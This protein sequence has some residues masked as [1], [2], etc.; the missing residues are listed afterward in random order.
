VTTSP[1]N[2]LRPTVS[3]ITA[4]TT[5]V[6]RTEQLAGEA[7]ARELDGVLVSASVSVRY[8]SGYTGSHGIVLL[9]SAPSQPWRFFTDFRYLT[10]AAEQVPERFERQIATN[11]FEAAL[12]SLQELGS[13]GGRLGFEDEHVSVAQH[14]KLLEELPSGWELVPCTGMVEGLRE[15]KDA[16]ELARIRAAAELVDEVLGWQA[17]RGLTGRSEREVALELEHE[18]RRRGA[19]AP[20]FPSIV[21]SGAQ[22]A[23]P[24]ASPRDVTIVRGDL[25]TIDMGALLDGY[26]SDCTRTFATAEPDGQ[27]REV[28]ATVLDAQQQGLQA[29]LA[30]SSGRQVDAVARAVIADAGYGENFGHGLGHGVGLEIHEAPRLSPSAPQEPLRPGHVVTVE[31]GV[32]LPAVLGV[33][34]EDL[35]VVG[36]DGPERL[37]HFPKELTVVG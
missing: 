16:G 8:L 13:Q 35:V 11:L 9:G 1:A 14:A 27:A 26:C 15:I 18:M 4:P 2:S 29:V 21:A 22:G 10:Q 17:E 19:T 32:Y 37:S 30:G 20:S 36:A 3:E 6:R 23:L 24:H 12:R 28:Y 25:V 5:L 7:V 31:P 33:R 34:I